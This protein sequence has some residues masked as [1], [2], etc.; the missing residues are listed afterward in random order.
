MTLHYIPTC[1][2]ECARR[3]ADIPENGGSPE[4]EQVISKHLVHSTHLTYPLEI[5]CCCCN[6]VP[7]FNLRGGGGGESSCHDSEKKR[8]ILLLSSASFIKRRRA[9]EHTTNNGG[10]FSVAFRSSTDRNDR[11]SSATTKGQSFSCIKTSPSLMGCGKREDA[12]PPF[13]VEDFLGFL[14]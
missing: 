7:L 1:P 8:P 2:L 6:R 4:Q 5:V 14:R 13:F 11:S 10:G 12:E 9:M 3:N